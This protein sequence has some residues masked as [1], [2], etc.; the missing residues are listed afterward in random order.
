[1]LL[2]Q[3]LVNMIKDYNL[4]WNI[5][6]KNLEN[7]YLHININNIQQIKILKNKTKI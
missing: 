6:N 7:S 4:I 3:N 1:M 2:H 5:S